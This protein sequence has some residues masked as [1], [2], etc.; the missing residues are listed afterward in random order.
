MQAVLSGIALALLSALGAFAFRY[1]RAYARLYP[2]LLWGVSITV[3]LVVTWQAAIE[4]AWLN[5]SQF[6]DGGVLEI[7][8]VAKN[9]LAAPYVRVGLGYVGIIAFLWAIRRLPRFISESEDGRSRDDSK[10]K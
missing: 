8:M 7:A 6:I 1:P 3:V 4:Y 2:Y 9:R 5:L 10:H